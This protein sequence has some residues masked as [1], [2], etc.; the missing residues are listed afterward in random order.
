MKKY[1]SKTVPFCLAVVF[2]VIVTLSVGAFAAN[3]TAP[4]KPHKLPSQSTALPY[5]AS[6]TIASYAYTNYNFQPNSRGIIYTIFTGTVSSDTSTVTI[7]LLDC[8]TGLTVSSYSLGTGSAWTDNSRGW[9]GLNVSH[10]YCFRVDKTAT[11]N[12][13]SFTLDVY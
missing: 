7:S 1:L 9:S 11:S 13:L 4:G 6:A 5:F 12:S 10:F 3:G 8:S 2:V